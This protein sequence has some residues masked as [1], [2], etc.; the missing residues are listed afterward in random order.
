LYLYCI[1]T[2]LIDENGSI[3]GFVTLSIP[4][5]PVESICG[6]K[7]HHKVAVIDNRTVN[8]D[9]LVVIESPL[10]AAHFT[11][12]GDRLWRCADLGITDAL[13]PQLDQNRSRCCSGVELR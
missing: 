5:T 3:S 11:R 2:S 10:L 12:E 7:L 1:S 8:D 4:E 13:S 9:V 6:G